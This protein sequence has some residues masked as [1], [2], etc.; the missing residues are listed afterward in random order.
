MIRRPPRSTLFPYTTLFRS[1]LHGSVCLTLRAGE[2]LL[3]SFGRCTQSRLEFAVGELR[4][5]NARS[6][7][8]FTLE[9][10]LLEGFNPGSLVR[11]GSKGEHRGFGFDQLLADDVEIVGD[12]VARDLVPDHVPN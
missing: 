9:L 6:A 4:A 11:N 8:H 12:P 1:G 7:R 3:L 10:H 2:K 5:F